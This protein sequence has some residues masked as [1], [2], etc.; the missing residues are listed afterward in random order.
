MVCR[1]HVR[2]TPIRHPGP[3]GNRAPGW[4]ILPGVAGLQKPIPTRDLATAAPPNKARAYFEDCG[5]H[6]FRPSS[7]G[8]E[9]LNAWW[10]AEASLLAYADE[11]FVAPRLEG[12]GLTDVRH[13]HGKSTQCYAAHNDEFAL[14]AFSGTDM[15]ERG[16]N[17]AVDA[18][19]DWLVN[20]TFDTTD[21]GHGGRVHRGFKQALDE[22]WNPEDRD[23]EERLKPYLDGVCEAGRKVWFTGHSLGGALATLA[24][25]RY[26][27]A[28]ELYTFGSPRVGDRAYAKGL[29]LS[30]YRFV[31]GR[32][33]VPRVPLKGPY[34]HVGAARRIDAEGRIHKGRTGKSGGLRRGLSRALKS[35]RPGSLGR[36]PKE[37]LLDHAPIYYAVHTW[38]S[39]AG[40]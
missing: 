8:F 10:L 34:R 39:Y 25:G 19:T 21:S 30:A 2:H 24:A 23:E 28:P 13:F 26:D 6:P 38:N 15:R 7:G 17:G 11:D 37:A 40:G 3:T 20:L 31:N 33:V 27:H 32:D 29:N 5:D 14:V 35:V 4:R 12:A 1:R 18:L 36:L 22:V 16:G 9:M